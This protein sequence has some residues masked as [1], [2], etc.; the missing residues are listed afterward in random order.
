MCHTTVLFLA[1]RFAFAAS[2]RCSI[3]WR[4]SGETMLADELLAVERGSWDALVVSPGA[5]FFLAGVLRLAV[6]A[7]MS[8]APVVLARFLARASSRRSAICRRA[9]GVT[10]TMVELLVVVL[11]SG[12]LL[13]LAFDVSSPNSKTSSSC[14]SMVGGG[15]ASGVP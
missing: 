15:L 8:N 2:R 14:S 11:D 4:A 12:A 1:R 6:S 7:S 13:R 9:A 3:C 10:L 5:V